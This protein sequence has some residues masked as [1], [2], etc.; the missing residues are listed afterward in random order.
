VAWLPDAS[1]ERGGCLVESGGTVIDGTVS[2]RWERA[3]AQLGLAR[4]W[5]DAGDAA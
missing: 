3:V 2:K 4:T 5:T 1:V